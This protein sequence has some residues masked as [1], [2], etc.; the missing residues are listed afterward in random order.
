MPV[1]SV[2][3]TLNTVSRAGMCFVINIRNWTVKGKI[4]MNFIL[5]LNKQ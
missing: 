2:Y 3:I 4:K 1:Y 5:K